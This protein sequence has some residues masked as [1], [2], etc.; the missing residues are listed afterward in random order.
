LDAGEVLAPFDY[1]SFVAVPDPLHGHGA[2]SVSHEG[3]RATLVC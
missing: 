3:G 2:G 1:A